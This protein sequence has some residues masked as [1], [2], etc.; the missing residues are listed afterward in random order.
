MAGSDLYAA[1]IGE[2][3]GNADKQAML[4]DLLRRKAGFAQVAQLTGD[5]SLAPMGQQQAGEVN[6]QAQMLQRSQQQQQQMAATQQQQ[7]AQARFQQQ[8]EARQAAAQQE[9]MAVT[10]RGQDMTAASALANTM[11][12]EKELQNKPAPQPTEGERKAATLATRL[13]GSLR[14]LDELGAASAK[15]GY[16]E[17]TLES[18][19]MESAANVTRSSARQRAN[20]A[21]LDAL[22][23]ALTLGTGATYTKEQLAN[24]KTQY[25]PQIGD[26]AKTIESKKNRFETIVNAARTAAGRAAP[27]IDA[28]L[29]PKLPK[30]R[31]KVDAQGN[32]I[33]N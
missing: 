16:L 20:A 5:A 22:D 8:Q 19:G 29:G 1:M 32:V 18:A 10:R 7:Q 28:A 11:A 25:F 17:K 23:A 31:V 33:G 14:E 3:I 27:A 24:F 13:E 6:Q 4:A 2:P 12:R 15:P 30:K 26:D 9:Q 21:Q